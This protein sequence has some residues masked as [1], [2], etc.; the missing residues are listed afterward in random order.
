[1]L[2]NLGGECGSIPKL[3]N[4]RFR[5]NSRNIILQKPSVKKKLKIN[6]DLFDLLKLVDGYN[7]IKEISKTLSVNENKVKEVF[8]SLNK[9]GIINLEKRKSPSIT[10]F[11]EYNFEY[12]LDMIYFEPTEKCN[13]KCIHCYAS[14]PQKKNFE[15]EMGEEGLETLVNQ[16]DKL[17]IL[18]VCFTGGEPFCS[19]KTLRLSKKFHNKGLK[20]GYITNGSLISKKIISELKKLGPSFIR[21]SFHSHQKEKFEKITGTQNYEKVLDNLMN[22]KK[23][24]IVPAISCI[25][26]KGLND[27]YGDG[28]YDP[29]TNTFTPT[30]KNKE[31]LEEV[32]P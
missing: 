25:M 26:F 19:E 18:E 20:L 5:K 2:N 12:P 16:I 24:G 7:S 9:E 6:K 17:G 3:K 32:N 15:H 28:N 22:L 13:F 29:E 31:V 14:A 11:C 21:M 4:V 8:T 23:E 10:T 30:E 1:M 27:I